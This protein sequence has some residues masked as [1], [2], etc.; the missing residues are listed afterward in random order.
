MMA[1]RIVT[2]A[3]VMLVVT[4]GDALAQAE[5][6]Q[7]GRRLRDFEVAWEKQ[8]DP[9]A[10]RK[11][12]EI[13]PAAST[14]FLSL[15]LGEAGRTLDDARRALGV[16]P[17]LPGMAYL[18]ALD[19]LPERRVLDATVTTL[20]V[21][22]TA[23]YPVKGEVPASAR[24]RL[25]FPG[26]RPV[27]VP[28]AEYRE[29]VSVPL[30]AA[31]DDADLPLM[32]T[33]LLDSKVVSERIT[34]ISRVKNL[35]DRIQKLKDQ[36]VP[37]PL[38]L[39]GA[40]LQERVDLLNDLTE[41]IPETDYPTA[42]LVA[43]GETLARDLSKLYYSPSRAGNFWIAIPTGKSR[44]AARLFV[45]EKLDPKQPVPIVIG[46][47]GA[48]G[49]ENLFFDGYGAGRAVEECRKRGWL[50]LAPRS[51]LGFL[52]GP[53]AVAAMVDELAKRYPIDRKRVFVVGHSMGGAQGV[54]LVQ[55]SPGLVAGLAVLGASGRVRKPETFADLP[56]YIGVGTKDFALSGSRSLAKS[57]TAIPK[58]KTEIKEYPDL[59]HMLIVRE[60]LPDAF[61][62]FE[63]VGR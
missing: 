52:G 33:L 12:L 41:R 21:K 6:Y 17:N 13:V 16:G 1:I 62:R 35:T 10:R 51:G 59:D 23:L 4:A 39:E 63:A 11:A 60:A 61:A 55:Q 14:K 2:I 56:V 5:R 26:A 29:P 50:F 44:T 19:F 31:M 32:V 47:H 54:E 40:S 22:K 57:L 46:L 30:P 8:P 25:G 45:P 49:S 3:L 7:L 58:T 15:Q 27:E 43:E 42:A 20:L 36:A 37:K 9:A 38:T 24:V 34:T 18:D 28:L 53:P 48:G